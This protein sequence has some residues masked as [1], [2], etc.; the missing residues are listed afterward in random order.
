VD[1]AGTLTDIHC[2]RDGGVL[3]TSIAAF[4]SS[5]GRIEANRIPN[6]EA[7]QRMILDTTWVNL[8][9]RAQWAWDQT[10]KTSPTSA[11]RNRKAA[12]SGIVLT[13]AWDWRC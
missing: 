11:R 4:A 3:E 10:V 12:F 13:L 7:H 5:G 2:T 1:I 6:S 9:R 8:K